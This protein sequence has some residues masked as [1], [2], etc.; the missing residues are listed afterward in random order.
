MTDVRTAYLVKQLELAVRSRLESVARRL[1]LTTPQFTALTVLRTAPGLSSA[2]L[3]RRSF[4]SAQS[5]QEMVAALERKGLIVR[6][7]D[8]GN[9]RI[10]RARLTEGGHRILTDSDTTFD[11]I[12]HDMTADLDTTQVQQLRLLL[13]LCIN[14]LSPNGSAGG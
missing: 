10:L 2:E 8:P 9:R 12:E 1:G 7:P 4:V 6:E 5:M 13:G 11:R 14:R 3:A